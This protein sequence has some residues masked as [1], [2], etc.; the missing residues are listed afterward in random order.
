MTKQVLKCT[1]EDL[2]SILGK[3]SPYIDELSRPINDA[4]RS[5]RKAW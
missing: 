2:L 5:M 4:L 1:A 3:D